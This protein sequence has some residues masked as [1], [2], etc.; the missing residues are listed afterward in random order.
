MV[1]AQVGGAVETTIVVALTT[2]VGG[3]AI[4][5]EGEV[6]LNHNVLPSMLEEC[7]PAVNLQ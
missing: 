2:V 5:I 6:K 3:A 4:M 1:D 7:R